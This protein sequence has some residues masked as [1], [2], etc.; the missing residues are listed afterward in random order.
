MTCIDLAALAT[1][2]GGQNN[3]PAIRVVIPLGPTPIRK[4]DAPGNPIDNN[5]DKPITYPK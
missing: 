2:T 1:V 5:T 3:G 4:P